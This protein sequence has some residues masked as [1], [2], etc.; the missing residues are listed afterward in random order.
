MKNLFLIITIIVC[1]SILGLSHY[2]YNQKLKNI[3]AEAHQ[4]EQPVIERLSNTQSTKTSNNESDDTDLSG[5]V[6][7][8]ISNQEEEENISVTFFG[9]LSLGAPESDKGWPMLVI[10]EINGM[11]EKEKLKPTI[12][13][14]NRSSSLDVYN[15]NYF[16]TVIESNPDLLIVEP[17]ILNDNGIV[18]IEDT[19]YV[20]EQFL[21]KVS[22][23]LPET[24]V[25]I[26]P[27]NP[28]EGA[29]YYISQVESVA[30]FAQSS[31]YS[32]V[33][34]WTAWPIDDNL[35]DYLEN[36]RPNQQGHSIW[37]EFMVNYLT[38]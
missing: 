13:N 36:N 28:V 6:G 32:F 26:I 34:H 16:D 38:N 22:D 1:V 19:L 35:S 33:D 8:L 4:F 20:L 7:N 29:V 25:L 5:I 21:N 15:S 30:E 37:A 14:V 27:P 9:S 23:K 31:G 17:F 12:V 11:L 2:Q 3:A 24:E 10:S 18:R